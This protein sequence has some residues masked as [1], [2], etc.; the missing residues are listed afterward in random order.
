MKSKTKIIITAI[1]AII[2][3]AGVVAA[4]KRP[5]FFQKIAT[6][7]KGIVD[8]IDISKYVSKSKRPEG[9]P[10]TI[11]TKKIE[12]YDSKEKAVEIDSKK[13]FTSPLGMKFI[14]I[15]PG[16]FRM[17]SPPDEPGRWGDDEKQ[18]KV[19]LTKGFYIQTTELTQGQWEKLM[20]KN[21]SKFKD[22]GEDCPVEN[23]SWD[24]IQDF[25]DKLNKQESTDKYR[26]P[27][28]AEWEYACRAGS[29]TAYSFGSDPEKLGAYALYQKN[30][31]DKPHPVA[32]K[33]PNAWGL[34][35]MHGSV[36][37]WCQDLYGEYP[38]DSISDPMGSSGSERVT[39][40]ASWFDD[41]TYCRSADRSSNPANSAFRDLGF[42]LVKSE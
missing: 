11:V 6:K 19:T 10:I 3:C 2:L 26:L 25:I 20:K 8:S 22:C 28:E 27:T 15:H 41:A 42:R 7:V 38:S 16:K 40:G 14:Y 39:R 4:Y 24:D 29:R 9:K 30:S 36:A 5:P 37:E 32:Q 18:H 33:K 21:P 31:E 34:Y 23:V 12:P 35:D 1:I 13:I 17:G